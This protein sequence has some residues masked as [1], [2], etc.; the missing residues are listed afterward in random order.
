[1]TL[2]QIQSMMDKLGL[3]CTE[4]VMT[5]SNALRKYDKM[6]PQDIGRS[7]LSNWH[8]FETKYPDTF[9]GMYQFWCMKVK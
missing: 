7:N 5:D 4:F 8:D 2:P 3:V 9:L 1:M 6:Y